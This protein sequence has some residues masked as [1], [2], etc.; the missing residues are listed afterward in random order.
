MLQFPRSNR[1][2]ISVMLLSLR[3][4]GR[5]RRFNDNNNLTS[6][7]IQNL[8]PSKNAPISSQIQR[9][10]MLLQAQK[11]ISGSPCSL[12]LEK[13]VICSKALS[14]S[15]RL[16]SLKLSNR[17]FQLYQSPDIFNSSSSNPKHC[18]ILTPQLF[19]TSPSPSPSSFFPAPSISVSEFLVEDTFLKFMLFVKPLPKPW[20]PTTPNT[21]MQPLL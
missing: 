1:D 12:K 10:A 6:L 3:R 2:S 5:G 20:L 21:T 9:K 14:S 8:V 15:N 7:P 13:Q 11:M 19:L 18:K 4:L 16:P 17:R